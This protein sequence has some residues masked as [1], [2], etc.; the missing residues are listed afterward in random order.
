MGSKT[1]SVDWSHAL[2]D[3]GL[4]SITRKLLQGCEKGMAIN[5][6]CFGKIRCRPCGGCSGGLGD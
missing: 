2:R 3:S 6:F 4:Y 5:S 1:I